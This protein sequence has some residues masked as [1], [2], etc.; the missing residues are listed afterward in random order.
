[1]ADCGK[2]KASSIMTIRYEVMIVLEEISRHFVDDF[3]SF[4]DFI[5]SEPVES[6]MIESF[7]FLYIL[8]FFRGKINLRIAID[9]GT[10]T[11]I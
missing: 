9:E 6:N 4:F 10:F 7:F 2:W 11:V 8:F 3:F 5:G 1:M